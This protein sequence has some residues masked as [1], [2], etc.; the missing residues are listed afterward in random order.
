M[1][2][3][4]VGIIAIELVSRLSHINKSV[5]DRHDGSLGDVGEFVI[6]KMKNNF[7]TIEVFLSYLAQF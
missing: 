1:E 3:E 4:M 2:K 5:F 7:I 6:S